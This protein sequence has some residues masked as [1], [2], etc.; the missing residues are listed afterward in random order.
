VLVRSGQ[1]GTVGM[2]DHV[3]RD[4]GAQTA[5]QGAVGGEVGECRAGALE[6]GGALL[7][8]VA[9]TAGAA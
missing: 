1:A 9:R 8:T 6:G 4:D 3:V 7:V 5:G 2:E